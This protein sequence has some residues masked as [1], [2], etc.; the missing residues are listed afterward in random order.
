MVFV[1]IVIGMKIGL[2][3]ILLNIIVYGLEFRCLSIT[4]YE[5][6]GRDEI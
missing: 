4:I 5:K 2:I 6:S 1:M 3:V